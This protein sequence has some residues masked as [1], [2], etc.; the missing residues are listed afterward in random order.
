MKGGNAVYIRFFA[1][2][3]ILYIGREGGGGTWRLLQTRKKEHIDKVRLINEDL[4]EENTLS[5][6]KTNGQR[7]GRP[8]T[9]HHGVPKW[10]RLG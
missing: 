10:Y 5:A 2:A 8:S 3:R 6:K 9:A 7:G 4:H 1:P